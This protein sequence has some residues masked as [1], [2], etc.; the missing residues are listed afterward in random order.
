[1]TVAE[2]LRLLAEFA[3]TG[4]EFKVCGETYY[5]KND[6]LMY[7]ECGEISVSQIEL[8]EFKGVNVTRLP[9]KPKHGEVYYFV[10]SS[11]PCGYLKASNTHGLHNL[12]ISRETVYRTEAEA[13]EEVRKRG[14]KVEN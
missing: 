6:L 8:N 11:S 1:M 2:K 9:F 4:E 10:T 13:Q 14:W 12:R 7:K 3:E 5:F